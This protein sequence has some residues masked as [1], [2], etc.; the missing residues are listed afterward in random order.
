MKETGLEYQ[1]DKPLVGMVSRLTYQKGLDL[2]EQVLPEL[3]SSR[4]M[5]LVVLGNGDSEYE[6]FFRWM[7]AEYPGRV[8]FFEGF[9]NPLA[10]RIEAGSDMFLMPSRYE[11]CGLNQMYSLKYGTVPVV[12]A[13]G[14]LTDSV[15]PYDHAKATGTGVVFHDYDASGLKWALNTALD[16][17]ENKYAWKQIVNNGMAK[18]FSWA[19]QGRIYTE[20]FRRL[21]SLSR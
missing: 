3:L 12:R 5:S 13:T 20:R 18:D 1:F 21:L 19:K 15:Q 8:S 4:E 14:G 16:L 11:P 9:N 7:H 10:H 6:Q 17:Y 2:V